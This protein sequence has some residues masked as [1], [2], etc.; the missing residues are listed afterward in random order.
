M[1]FKN[2]CGFSLLEVVIAL[3]ISSVVM[4]ILLDQALQAVVQT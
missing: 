1:T 2:S 3:S 4:L